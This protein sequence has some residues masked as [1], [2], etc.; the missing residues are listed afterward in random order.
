MVIQIKYPNCIIFAHQEIPGT[1]LCDIW[2][3]CWF[4]FEFE[5]QTEKIKELFDLELAFP[6]VAPVLT[7]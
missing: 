6:D 2:Q 1:K 4:L 5:L 3:L 7:V